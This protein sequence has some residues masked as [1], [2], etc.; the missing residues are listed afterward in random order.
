MGEIGRLARTTKATAA[1][2]AVLVAPPTAAWGA[3]VA[4]ED[5]SVV[6][7]A[8][9][10]EVNIVTMIDRSVVEE[11]APL[12]IGPGCTGPAPI[13]CG[14]PSMN[15]VLRLG[16]RDDR[17]EHRSS[18]ASGFVYGGPGGG[19][20]LSGGPAPPAFRGAGRVMTA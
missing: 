6:Y 14:D 19:G 18:T 5:D 12:V 11:S 13:I 20:H 2:A 1:I 15:G 7:R 8:A 3:T 9:R 10:G 16:D 4:V 17:G